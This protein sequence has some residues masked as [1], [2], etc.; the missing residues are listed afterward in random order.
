MPVSQVQYVQPQ[1]QYQ[2]YQGQVFHYPQPSLQPLGQ[3]MQQPMQQQQPPTQ[4]GQLKKRRKKKNNGVLGAAPPLAVGQPAPTMVQPASVPLETPAVV[5][6]TEPAPSQAPQDVPVLA[7]P[8]VKQKKVGRC[9]KCAVNTHATK[10]CKAVHYCLVCDS[11]AHPTIRCPILKLL[12]PTSFFV[13]F[14]NDA[15]LDRRLPDSVFK[16]QLIVSGAP[17]A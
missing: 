3:P 16:P 15:T 7:A 4:P 9:W 5:H 10:D 11:G 1:Q 12:R 13:G 17:I 6:P 8:I 2:H 14:G